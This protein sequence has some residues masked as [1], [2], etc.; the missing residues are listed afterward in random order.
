MIMQ[1]PWP[2]APGSLSAVVQT[3]VRSLAIA[4]V[5]AGPAMLPALAYASPPDP[6]W[7]AGIYDEADYDD[8]VLFAASTDGD[9]GFAVFAGVQELPLL[10]RGVAQAT[11]GASVALL[12]SPARPRAPPLLPSPLRYQ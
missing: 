11:E 4:L 5:L 3:L 9:I 2:I 1:T 6:S 10:L 8:V 7:L 12:R